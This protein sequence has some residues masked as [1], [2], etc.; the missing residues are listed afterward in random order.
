MAYL[1]VWLSKLGLVLF[2]FFFSLFIHVLLRNMYILI[3]FSP[4]PSSFGWN[5]LGISSKYSQDLFFS[6]VVVLLH[7]YY[8]WWRKAHI[9]YFL[10]LVVISYIFFLKEIEKTV[11]P[12]CFFSAV[13][14]RELALGLLLKVL[15]SLQ[16]CK[17]APH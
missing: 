12:I 4:L 1:M 13:F 14:Q 6:A 11:M 9:Q 8:P 16:K 17:L 3:V 2:F 5:K 10:K 15:P 7:Y